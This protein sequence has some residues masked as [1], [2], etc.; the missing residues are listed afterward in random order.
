[1]CMVNGLDTNQVG[2]RSDFPLS[3]SIDQPSKIL[4]VVS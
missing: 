2:M 1:M 3:K 4:I